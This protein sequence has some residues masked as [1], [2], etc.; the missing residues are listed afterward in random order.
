MLFLILCPVPRSSCRGCRG[1]LPRLW[2]SPSIS[3]KALSLAFKVSHGW[4]TA[5]PP[6]SP[7]FPPPRHPRLIPTSA[8]L[9]G[10]PPSNLFQRPPQPPTPGSRHCLCHDLRDLDAL[11]FLPHFK[12]VTCSSK[13][14]ALQTLVWFFTLLQLR[15]WRVTH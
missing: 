12:G 9:A 11:I 4:E 15:A 2:C 8:P 5:S 13:G 1:F 3:S 7:F 10:G 6:P 14:T